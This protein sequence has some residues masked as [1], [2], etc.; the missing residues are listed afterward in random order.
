[1]TDFNTYEQSE[2]LSAP[3]L[4][5]EFSDGT[6]SWRYV[7]GM[8]TAFTF[9]GNSYTPA[10]I[11]HGEIPADENIEIEVNTGLAFIADTTNRFQSPRIY[12]RIYRVQNYEAALYRKMFY[13]WVDG[14]NYADRTTK[15]ICAH[16]TAALNKRVVKNVYSSQCRHVLYGAACGLVANDH[17]HAGTITEITAGTYIAATVFN[18]GTPDTYLSS[19]IITEDGE[20]RTILSDPGTGVVVIARPFKDATVATTFYVYDKCL[21]TLAACIAFSNSDNFGGFPFMKQ[22]PYSEGIDEAKAAIMTNPIT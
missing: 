11:K 10:V 6:T 16:I 12:I 17:K 4:L 7:S 3:I 19:K 13:G 21:R 15:I 8:E 18:A 9:G 22:N 5:Y 20:E 1:M 2:R 14:F